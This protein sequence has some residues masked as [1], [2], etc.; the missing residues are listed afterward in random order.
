MIPDIPF[1][2]N[3]G[4]QGAFWATTSQRDVLLKSGHKTSLAI[5]SQGVCPTYHSVHSGGH[6]LTQLHTWTEQLFQCS[7][8]CPCCLLLCIIL[9]IM[10]DKPGAAKLWLSLP[11][12]LNWLHWDQRRKNQIY[13]IR[14]CGKK[15]GMAQIW[16]NMAASPRRE[17]SQ[18][19]PQPKQPPGEGNV[20][21]ASLQGRRQ[22]WLQSLRSQ[23]PCQH[24]CPWMSAD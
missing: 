21:P 12:A 6:T 5:D 19:A 16:Q 20:P 13:T 11:L 18:K 2:R 8:P 15:Q 3:A 23:S 24:F 10:D 14:Q 1:T 22:A 17:R 4:Q 7:H 9:S